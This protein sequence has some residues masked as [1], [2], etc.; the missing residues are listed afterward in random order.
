MSTRILLNASAPPLISATTSIKVVTGR[1]IAKTVGFMARSPGR[2]AD[3]P[4]LK[5][6]QRAMKDLFLSSPI[7]QVTGVGSKD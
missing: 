2:P 6:F 5:A 3:R 4:N 1:L 7:I